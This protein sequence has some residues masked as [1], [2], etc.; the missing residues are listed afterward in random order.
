MNDSQLEESAQRSPVQPQENALARIRSQLPGLAASEA[1]VGRWVLDH[2]DKVIYLSMA[3]VGEE[4]E[5][6]DTTV[7]RFCRSLGF[8]G[9]TDLKI[10][11]ARD[12]A[13]PTQSI[14]S[15]ISVEDDPATVAR[16]V[17]MS[18]IQALHDTIDVLDPAALTRAVELLR[19]ARQIL[20]VGVGTSGPIVRDMHNKLFRLGLN[21]SAETD[22]YLQLMKVAL[23]GPEDLVVAISQSGASVDPVLTLK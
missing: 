2:A 1:R 20:I 5:V 23:L 12:L 10:S 15:E 13:S 11:L 17:F 6:S 3:R 22:S 19:N 7:L 9:F 21:C 18:H 8:H 16:A 14:Q 4:C